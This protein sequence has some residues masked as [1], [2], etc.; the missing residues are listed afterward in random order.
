MAHTISVGIPIC[1]GVKPEWLT[2]PIVNAPADAKI[3]RR[4]RN[5]EA[6]HA[7]VKTAAGINRFILC[8]EGKDA[9]KLGPIVGANMK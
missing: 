1:Y 7:F 3:R 8:R 6:A 5:Q 2:M 4:F 9:L